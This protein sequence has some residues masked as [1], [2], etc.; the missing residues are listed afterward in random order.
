MHQPWETGWELVNEPAPQ[1]QK[2]ETKVLQ[3]STYN[4]W[5]S[6]DGTETIEKNGLYFR[7]SPGAFNSIPQGDSLGIGRSI[8]HSK[9]TT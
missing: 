8:A 1:S 6:P 3:N 9:S 2:V 7:V 4:L 5:K